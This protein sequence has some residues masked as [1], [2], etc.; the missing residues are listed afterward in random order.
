MKERT[1]E[2]KKYV[3]EEKV[4]K[5]TQRERQEERQIMKEMQK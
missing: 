2:G 1:T 5:E 3:E 4:K